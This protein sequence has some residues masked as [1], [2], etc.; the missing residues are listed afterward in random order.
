MNPRYVQK[1]LLTFLAQFPAVV[2]IGPRQAGKTT[3][4]LAEMARR[5]DAIYLDLELPSAQRQMDDPESFL[6]AQRNRLVILDEVQRL[7]ELFAVLRGVIDIRRRDGEASGQFLLL[8]SATGVL[9]Q[10]ASESLAG[11]VAQLEL[12]PFQACE[13]LPADAPGP[14]LNS[15]W[16]RGG[17]PL[18][19]LAHDE[20]SSLRWREAF[21]ATYL[22]RDI[23]ALGPKIPTTTLRRLWTM[24]AHLQGS[25]LNQS[26]LAASLAVSGQTVSRY[27]DVLCDLMLIRRLPAWHGNVGKRLVRAPKV[28]VRDSGITHAL[29]GLESLESILSHPVAGPSWEG[30]V[31]EQLIAAAFQAEASFYRTS[32][33]AEA[34]LVMSFR[35]G[36]TW[37]IEIKRSSAP[38][39]SKGFHLAAADVGATRKL[40]VAPVDATYPVRDGIEVMNPLTAATQLT[41][42]CDAFS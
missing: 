23:P 40:L 34:D 21:I 31:I 18:S 1:K 7:P 20:T 14:A 3:L 38:A 5:G 32:H 30:F 39:V 25:L 16:V 4:A 37:V 22:E 8:G 35:N 24:L 42:F 17:F 2:L 12:T 15:L 19:W 26:Q 33:G 11:R 41:S 13:V 6:L 10:Q 29:L 28:Y 36:E 27:I 9:L